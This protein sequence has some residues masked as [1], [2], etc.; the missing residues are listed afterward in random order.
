MKLVSSAM[1]TLSDVEILSKITEGELYALGILFDRYEPSIKRFIGR[2]GVAR[3]DV[4]DL[5]QLT[6]LDVLGAAPRFDD[7]WPCRSWLLG[8][9]AVVV[10]RYR[11]SLKRQA[12]RLAAWA[13]EP[14]RRSI[15]QPDD[16]L[17]RHQGA[18]RALRALQKL[19]HRKREV[20]V[21]LVFEDLS[22]AEA[23]RALGVPLATVWTRMHHARRDLR[24]LIK[25]QGR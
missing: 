23:A 12:E 24:R 3:A 19:S 15:P 11:R 1:T 14:L 2:L 16:D 9:A 8:L 20:F 6:F 10:R 17:E 22:G 4:D 5:V 18:L 7:R 13:S 21:M 25:E